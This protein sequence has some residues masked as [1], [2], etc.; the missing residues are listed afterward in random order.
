[1][2]KTSSNS[3]APSTHPAFDLVRQQF[4]PALSTT[5]FE[6]RHKKT[7]AVHYHL[8]NQNPE[9]VFLV[10]FRTQ[11]MDS[12]GTAHMLDHTALCGSQKYPVR[13]PFF[14]M[15]RRSLNTFMNAFTAADWTAYPFATQNDKDFNNLLSV[16][17]DAA[18]HAN[19]NPLDFAQEGI[20]VELENDRPVYKG[21][22]FNEMKGAMSA[23][24]DQ[25][26]HKLAH[27]LYPKTTYHYNSGGDPK[28]IPDLSYEQLKAFYQSHYH[29]SNAVLMSF[30]DLEV[31]EF[32]AQVES[33]ALQN[34]E[35]EI[36]RAHV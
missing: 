27:H 4:I 28:D 24:T 11:P 9:K 26:Y 7:N 21:I 3:V 14:S 22:V 25:L 8:G 17:L 16:Y 34:F 19:L 20:R 29:P 10:A 30:G 31:T 5:V 33:Q 18:F 12:K 36:G 6:Y 23:A 32:H 13:D 1:M 2:S 35:H 15:I